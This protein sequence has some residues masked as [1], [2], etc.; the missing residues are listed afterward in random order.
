[1]VLVRS[2]CACPQHASA[3]RPPPDGSATPAH[4]A[5]AYRTGASVVKHDGLRALLNVHSGTSRSP[6]LKNTVTPAANQRHLHHT[7]KPIVKIQC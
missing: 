7:S 3:T 2:R 1:M 5:A 6:A 4:A